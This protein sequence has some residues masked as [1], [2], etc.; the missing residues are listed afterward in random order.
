MVL[1][2]I[3]VVVSGFHHSNSYAFV[4]D[5]A[6]QFFPPWKVEFLPVSGK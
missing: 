6:D 2:T 4:L 3:S 1:V 5:M